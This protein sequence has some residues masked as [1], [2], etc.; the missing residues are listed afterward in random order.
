[1]TGIPKETVRRHVDSMVS[2]GILLS[3]PGGLRARPG[4]ADR[5]AATAILRSVEL[6]A[7]CTEQLIN[8]G[9]ITTHAAGP[10]GSR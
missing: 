8:L 9:A 5:T 10:A 2:R 7:A 6:H 3:M 4:L 1:M